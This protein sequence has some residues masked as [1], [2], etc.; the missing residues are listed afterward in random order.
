MEVPIVCINQMFVYLFIYTCE[1]VVSWY[2][3]NFISFVITLFIYIAAIFAQ[4]NHHNIQQSLLNIS[5]RIANKQ[6]TLRLNK[7]TYYFFKTKNIYFM[8]IKSYEVFIF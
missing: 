3:L 5:T 2:N 1:C 6:C 7:H 8:Q 4:C